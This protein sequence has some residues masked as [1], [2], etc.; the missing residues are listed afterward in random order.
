MP[1]TFAGLEIARRS[2]NTNE[3]VL[4]VV[5]HNIANASTD[6]YTRQTAVV[7]ATDPYTVPSASNTSP[8]QF[9]T[10]VA[11]T[12]IDQARDTLMRSRLVA[13][14]GNEGRLSELTDNLARIEV[15]YDESGTNGISNKMTTFF[16]SF[17][18]LSSKPEDQASR[19]D[20]IQDGTTLAKQ[21][22]SVSSS[23]TDVRTELVH[24]VST[25]VSEVNKDASDIA[26]LNQQIRV[27][28]ATGTQPN[29]LIDK[30]DQ[31]VSKLANYIG[32]TATPEKDGEGNAT[33][34]VTVS[35]NGY[36]L[37]Q[38]D[39]A[40][41][42]PDTYTIASDGTA[43]ITTPTQNI[44][45]TNGSLAGTITSIG[46]IDGYQSDLD[47]I[48][49]TLITQVNTLHSTGY[50]LDG[51]TG[52]N[53]FT[54]TSASTI[55]VSDTI[56][57]NPNEVA[58]ATAPLSTSTAA[59]GNGTNAQ[60]IADLSNKQIFGTY[61]ILQKY[62]S[63][64]SQIGSDAASYKSQSSDATQLATQLDTLRSSIEG[65]SLDEELTSMLQ[66]QRS[67]QAAARLLTVMDGMLNTLLT[68][69]SG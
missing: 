24:R 23:L 3:A 26:D 62:N 45:V 61:T 8:G 17:Q 15:C 1:S 41:Q 22:N 25:T 55:A 57:S 47:T 18:Q 31:L 51:Q 46:L 65:V 56:S 14:Q 43:Q 34:C 32:A 69:L 60:A 4:D 63:N 50:G 7:E 30:R 35:V 28:K 53:F 58:A 10:G 66:Y 6:G 64:I 9:G 67:Y 54:G 5:G 44:S 39:S 21:F 13:I 59:T 68:G 42:L 36:A 48:A 11:V 49:S 52:R 38:G 27:A 16:N 37:V 20:V 40:K 2:L 12:A 29:D 33:G 19:I